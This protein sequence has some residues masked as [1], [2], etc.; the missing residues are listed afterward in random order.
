MGEAGPGFRSDLIHKETVSCVYPRE[1]AERT[2][3]CHDQPLPLLLYDYGRA[4][5]CVHAR[6]RTCVC[7]NVCITFTGFAILGVI[8]WD[9][10]V[11]VFCDHYLYS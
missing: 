3:W 5:V 4:C 9:S 1:A 7:G 6:A 8:Q 2:L 10:A 11:T